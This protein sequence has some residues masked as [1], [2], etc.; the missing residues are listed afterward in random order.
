MPDR[1]QA[2]IHNREDGTALVRCRS[3]HGQALLEVSNPFLQSVLMAT[4]ANTN[5]LFHQP[6]TYSGRAASDEGVDRHTCCI[7]QWS[8]RI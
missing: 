6:K 7:C 8:W 5:Q 4:E 3:C 1:V 2:F